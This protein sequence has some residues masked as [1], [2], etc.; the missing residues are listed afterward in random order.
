MS[1]IQIILT[2][3]L[4][5]LGVLLGAGLQYYFSRETEAKKQLETLRTMA[6][7]DFIRSAS[8]LAIYQRIKDP[9]KE[10]EAHL[11]MIDSKTRIAIYGS[12]AVVNNLAT[13]WRGGPAFDTPEKMKTFTLLIQIIRNECL[14][15]D[16]VVFDKEISQLLFSMDL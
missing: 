7:I 8:E 9:K 12:K 1:T 3:V 10:S 2:S 11:L 13:F 14:S 4:P 6:Y 15:K 5:I 16:Q